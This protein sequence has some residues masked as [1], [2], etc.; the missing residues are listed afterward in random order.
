MKHRKN[1]DVILYENIRESFLHGTFRFGEKID[2]DS[3][4]EEYNVSRTPVVQALHRLE[5]EGM[6][7]T[8]PTGKLVVPEFSTAV[9]KEIY[10]IR[11]LIE[12]FAIRKIVGANKNY[13]FSVMKQYVAECDAAYKKRDIFATSKADM[14]FHREMVKIADNGC[15][16]NLYD[17]IQGQCMV[18]NYLLY[19]NFE[20]F[21][22][23]YKKEHNDIL[24]SIE[25]YE[26]EKALFL[27]SHH[28]EHIAEQIIAAFPGGA[29]KTTA[30][31]VL[32]GT[33]SMLPLLLELSPH[34]SM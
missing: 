23:R 28:L 33:L 6:L 7:E 9:I 17:R 13:D 24:D 15:L 1:L 14:N 5:C 29:R 22:K 34:L 12:Q 25:E 27:V 18:I 19:A 3:L 10:E 20:E 16:L 26:M 31:S 4:A 2:I 8:G 30:R 32:R 11:A 21:Y